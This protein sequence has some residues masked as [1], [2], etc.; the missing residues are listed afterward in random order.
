MGAWS[1]VQGFQVLDQGRSTMSKRRA[2]PPERFT[3]RVDGRRV[4]EEGIGAQTIHMRRGR[5]RV[6]LLYSDLG[7]VRPEAPRLPACVVEYL[8]PLARTAAR[9]PESV[10]A[11]S[12]QNRDV[13]LGVEVPQEVM[14]EFC[15]WSMQMMYNMS[16]FP[17]VMEVSCV[18]CIPTHGVFL[19]V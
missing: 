8:T 13:T 2:G 1:K 3:H 18:G 9:Y 14:T 19:L 12:L 5:P 11:Y 7:P 10:L 16:V 4:Y 17:V 6:G 15:E